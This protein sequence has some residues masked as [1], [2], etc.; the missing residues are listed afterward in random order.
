MRL[1]Q[2]AP[3]DGSLAN[4][5]S[6]LLYFVV[7]LPLLV[8][9]IDL[10]SGGEPYQAWFW[11]QPMGKIAQVRYGFRPQTSVIGGTK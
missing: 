9:L 7:F 4:P 5:R 1:I 6:S 8:L 2:R 11:D 10:A 3:S